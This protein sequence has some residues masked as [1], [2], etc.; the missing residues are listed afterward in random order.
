ME[1]RRSITVVNSH[2]P[3]IGSYCGLKDYDVFDGTCEVEYFF[4]QFRWSGE[5]IRDRLVL[6]SL[7]I[8][9][10]SGREPI[11]LTKDRLVAV[12]KVKNIKNI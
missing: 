7:V 2:V 12:W 11:A 10:Y 5:I 3:H 4:H 9:Q 6:E 1:T 8:Y